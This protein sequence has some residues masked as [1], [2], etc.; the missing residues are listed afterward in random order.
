MDEESSPERLLVASGVRK[1]KTPLEEMLEIR[2]QM[3]SSVE[4]LMNTA[5]KAVVSAQET[6][7][8]TE[9]MFQKLQKYC[10]E[11]MPAQMVKAL[12]AMAQEGFQKS[13]VPL[14]AG[15][16]KAAQDIDRCRNSL[17][18]TS[19]NWRLMLGAG[20]TMLAVLLIAG[21]LIYYLFFSVRIAEMKRLSGWGQKLE[22]RYQ[23]S[24]PKER[25]KLDQW[26]KGSKL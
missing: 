2:D 1:E 21:G 22:A 8:A 10:S 4:K 24:S 12:D 3:N 23:T 26:F 16:A 14:H 18:R 20:S 11:R 7:R 9:E 13:L 5:D 17:T 19:W 25:G 6:Q 15:V